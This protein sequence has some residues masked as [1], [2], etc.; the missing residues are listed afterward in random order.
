MD[1]FFSVGL[2][3]PELCPFSDYASFSTD[4]MESNQHDISK[5]FEQ[6]P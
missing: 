4:I 3:I 5:A 6:E 1:S 2:V